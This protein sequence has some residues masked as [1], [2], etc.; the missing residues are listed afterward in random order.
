[1]NPWRSLRGLPRGL[2]I[3]FA[4]TLVN[5]AGTMVLPF[6]ALYLTEEQGFSAVQ[7]G[8]ILALY[9][10]GSIAAAPAAGWLCDRVP[11]HRVME[12]SLV[13]SGIAAVLLPAAHGFFAIA[14][15]VVAWSVLAEFFRPASLAAIH[16]L[17]PA[18]KARTAVALQRLAINLGMS[19]G[20]ALGGFLALHSFRAV[21]VVDG[22]T[23][24]I[25]G[26]VMLFA[27]GGSMRTVP[28]SHAA[29]R[30][31]STGAGSPW[32]DRAFLFFLL[33]LL[34][35]GCVFF[36]LQSTLALFLVRDVHLAPSVYGLLFTVNT[37]LI[38]AIEVP[39]IA[40]IS[41]HPVRWST[42]AGSILLGIGFGSLA[43]ARGLGTVMASTII[44][45]CGEMLLLPALVS[46]A[47]TL[48]PPARRGAYMGLYTVAL[49]VTVIFG[50]WI[51][52]GLL[53]RAG[54]RALWFTCFF[55]ALASAAMLWRVPEHRDA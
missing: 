15:A 38:V 40:W 16:D 4:T 7:A 20:P 18:D 21:F 12:A 51:G 1:M 33:A 52:T 25:A 37:L 23:S 30:A 27:A 32:R 35:A 28:Q 53:E 9:G 42:T 17:A 47:G 43:F 10:L 45:T 48:S 11:A 41:H 3:L 36:Q 50:P 26:A 49:N 31:A 55:A 44:W 14:G 19:V 24:I 6:L 39:L 13:L 2:W 5:R 8:Q 34:P 54:P 29:E 46:Q 22:V